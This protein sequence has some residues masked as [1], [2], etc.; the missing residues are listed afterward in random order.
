MEYLFLFIAELLLEG[1]LEIS[2]NKKISK[3]I[4]YPLLITISLFFISILGL[5]LFLGIRLFKEN[6]YISIFLFFIDTFLFIGCFLKGK[7]TF[8]KKKYKQKENG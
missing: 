5:I 8:I 2:K 3:W 6:K 7:E 4:R 1:S